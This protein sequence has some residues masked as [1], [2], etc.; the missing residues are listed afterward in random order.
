MRTSQFLKRN[1]TYFWRTNVAVILGVAAAVAVL[2]GA[3]LVGDSVRGSLRD[4]FLERLGNTDQVVAANGFFRDQLAA[5][6][7]KHNQ[8]AAA[9]FV[10]AVPLIA[11]NGAITNE[12][13][14]QLSSDIQVYGVDE[15]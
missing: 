1:L 5:D 7:Q 15:R 11:V 13:S 14:R 2:A 9:G 3:L 8:F 10:A 12:S 6:I 4:L